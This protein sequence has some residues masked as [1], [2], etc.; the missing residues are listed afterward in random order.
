MT[1][2]PRTSG[3]NAACS[4]L[5]NSATSTFAPLS[6][7]ASPVS[8]RS[9]RL[10]RPALTPSPS[11]PRHSYF[12]F[13]TKCKSPKACTILLRGPSKDILHEIDRN[14]ADAMAVARNVVFDPRLA[15]GGG[16]TEMAISVGLS[17]KARSIEGV[18]GWPYRAV[19]EA[20]EVIPRTLVQNCGGNAIRVLTQ[21][22]V[23][24]VPLE[25]GRSCGDVLIVFLAGMCP[26]GQAR[27]GRA[28]VRC[29]RRDGQSRRHE[30]IRPVRVCRRQGADDQNGHRGAPSLVSPRTR[31][32]ADSKRD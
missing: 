11:P 26:T 5:T 6:D 29:R 23:R 4:T 22:R 24:F 32:D 9:A 8:V 10:P 28:P 7:F 19:S 18:E 25:N 15:P 14:L 13:L 3:P 1:C 27:G 17:K 2:A 20:M 21:L 16:A 12:T 30:G 31:V